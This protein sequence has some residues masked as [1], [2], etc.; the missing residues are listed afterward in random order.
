MKTPI[1]HGINIK[2]CFEK[3]NQVKRYISSLQN[4][5]DQYHKIAKRLKKKY[6]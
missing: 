3:Y 1:Q 5:F 6:N 4:R 2:K